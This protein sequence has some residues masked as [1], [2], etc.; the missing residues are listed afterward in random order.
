MKRFYSSLILIS[1]CLCLSG[2]D[3]NETSY[4]ESGE[5]T[6]YESE[7]EIYD[8]NSEI[9]LEGASKTYKFL[10]S[11]YTVT[12][13]NSAMNTEYEY[14]YYFIDGVVAGMR[15]KV[16]FSDEKQ[17]YDYYEVMSEQ[18]PFIA[19]ND[20]TVTYFSHSE[21]LYFDGYTPEQL[22]FALDNAGYDVVLNF[23]LDS[24]NKLFD[25]DTSG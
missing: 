20:T 14:E 21:K 16:T 24:F 8:V 19:M 6:S 18:D 1:V 5:D 3:V 2:C 12:A 22:C 15:A 23:D 17:A 7:E 4:Y 25:S 11:P 10:L 9:D 13:K